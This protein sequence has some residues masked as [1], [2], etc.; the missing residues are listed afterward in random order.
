MASHLLPM[1]RKG[2]RMSPRKP[3]RKIS[4][5][6]SP[7]KPRRRRGGRSKAPGPPPVPVDARARVMRMQVAAR[8]NARNRVVVREAARR[9]GRLL[10]DLAR[11]TKPKRRGAKTPPV[12][13][14]RGRRALSESGK[15]AAQ[16]RKRAKETARRLAAREG[17]STFFRAR[18]RGKKRSDGLGRYEFQLPLGFSGPGAFYSNEAFALGQVKFSGRVPA[19][20]LLATLN[21]ILGITKRGR[22]VEFQ[23]A[24][25]EWGWKY[26][27]V[28]VSGKR[29]RV[30]ERDGAHGYNSALY[31]GS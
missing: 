31:R 14:K 25:L 6:K 8:E 20:A 2:A 13:L 17:L 24:Y 5:K 27:V 22:R 23:K 15:R 1:R 16:I 3:A 11:V 30:I 26:Q 29:V 9:Q 18:G 10:N 4:R 7:G 21:Q 12:R 19:R 28:E